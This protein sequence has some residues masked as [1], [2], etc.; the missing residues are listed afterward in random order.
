VVEGVHLSGSSGTTVVHPPVEEGEEGAGAGVGYGGAAC[1]GQVARCGESGEALIDGAGEKA[2]AEFHHVPNLLGTGHRRDE[3]AHIGDMGE[4]LLD[5]GDAV[6]GVAAA[7][8]GGGHHFPEVFDVAEEKIVLVGVVG[9][10]SGAADFGAIEDV[11][12]S[13]GLEGLFVHEGD[14]SVAEAIAG[15]ANAAVDFLFGR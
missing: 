3:L 15:G 12:D 14:Q 11:L 7:N 13:D 8:Q 4:E 6:G 9:V 10:K 1:R 2:L 5:G